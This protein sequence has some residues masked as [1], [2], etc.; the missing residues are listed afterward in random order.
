MTKWPMVVA[1]ARIGNPAPQ[2]MPS[3]AVSQI[4][5]AVVNPRT[6]SRRIKER[7]PENPYPRRRLCRLVYAGLEIRVHGHPGERQDCARSVTGRGAGGIRDRLHRRR[8]HLHASRRGAGID[9][10]GVDLAPVSQA[11]FLRRLL[12]RR[13]RLDGSSPLLKFRSRVL[14][15]VLGH[16]VRKSYRKP[17]IMVCTPSQFI[18][19]AFRGRHLRSYQRCGLINASD[20]RYA[21]SCRH[22]SRDVLT[23]FAVAEFRKTGRRYSLETAA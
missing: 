13:H 2:A 18:S 6:T 19:P 14:E 1:T 12:T 20:L 4:D 22:H 16:L 3:A 10:G 15:G 5:A 8:H 9:H 11:A 17:T 7:G 23:A 21:T